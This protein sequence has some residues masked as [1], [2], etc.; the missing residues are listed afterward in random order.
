MK[1]GLES[2]EK[3]A[4]APPPEAGELLPKGPRSGAC[5]GPPSWLAGL[6]GPGVAPQAGEE[7]SPRKDCRCPGRVRAGPERCAQG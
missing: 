1:P 6:G 5:G 4:G 7:G 3:Q 2:Q